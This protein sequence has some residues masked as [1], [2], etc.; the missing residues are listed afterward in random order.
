MRVREGI[1]FS[2]N[3][4]VGGAFR[5]LRV[6][7]WP[8]HAGSRTST[9]GDRR[10]PIDDQ[11]SYVPLHPFRPDTSDQPSVVVLP[12]PEPYGVRR[13]SNVEIEKSLP[14]AVG[15]RPEPRQPG[16]ARRG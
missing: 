13:I 9:M 16:S 1:Q 7:A 8:G 5:G 6:R 2:V 10:S 11:A 3:D 14:D 15:A 4:L 12:V